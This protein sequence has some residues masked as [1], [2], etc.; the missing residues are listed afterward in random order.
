MNFGEFFLETQLDLLAESQDGGFVWTSN[1]L[2]VDP[3]VFWIMQLG[4][5]FLQLVFGVLIL[6]SEITV[7]EPM[8]RVAGGLR[9]ELQC[10]TIAG[11]VP[12]A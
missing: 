4:S 11:W 5:G 9:A 10:Q 8:F 3:T 1:L 7:F 12:G 6:A 2:A